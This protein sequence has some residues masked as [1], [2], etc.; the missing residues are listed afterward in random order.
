MSDNSFEE[1]RIKSKI[2]HSTG[3]KLTFK[4]NN[5]CIFCYDN[6]RRKTIKDKPLDRVKSEVI[7]LKNMGVSL[8]ALRGSEPTVYP[9]I[10]ELIRFIKK[11]GLNFRLSTNARL[12]YYEEVTKT[13]VQ[14]GL[15]EVYISLHSSKAEVHDNLTRVTGSFKQ[16]CNGIKNLLK[17]GVQVETNTTIL[18]QNVEHLEEIAQFLSNE[19]NRLYRARFSFLYHLGVG[20][21]IEAWRLIMP[22][23]SETKNNLTK[24]MDVLR[25]NNIYSFIEKLPVCGA[26]K[27]FQDFKPEDYVIRANKKPLACSSCRYYYDAY[28]VGISPVYLELYGDSDL[29]PQ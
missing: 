20:A 13:F 9:H 5:K 11:Q 10:L 15:A 26:P 1:L 28:C 29:T 17:Y 19:F 16:T 27:Y 25:G 14:N 18:R 4:C 12:F 3:I 8:I 21:D 2:P 23:L 6:T 22:S 24:A 7:R